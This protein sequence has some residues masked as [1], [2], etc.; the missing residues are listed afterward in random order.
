MLSVSGD[1]C[2]RIIMHMLHMH[3][4]L[5]LIVRVMDAVSFHLDCFKL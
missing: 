2:A 4:M 5:L 1:F 3:I